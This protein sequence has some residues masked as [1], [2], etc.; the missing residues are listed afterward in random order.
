MSV[1]TR[2]SIKRKVSIALLVTGCFLSWGCGGLSIGPQT[3]T[4]Y[5]M[6]NPGRPLL[7]LSNSTVTGRVIDATSDQAPVQ[8]DIGGWVAMPQSHFRVLIE[9]A[10]S[11]M[12]TVK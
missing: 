2:R 6:V 9:A 5:V 12:E 8:Q 3:K 1:K 11:S 10:Q 4:Q 7:I